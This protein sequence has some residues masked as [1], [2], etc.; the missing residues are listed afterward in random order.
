[1]PPDNIEAA[2]RNGK[3][4]FAGRS[5]D[6]ECLAMYIWRFTKPPGDTADTVPHR[7]LTNDHLA[8]RSHLR[9]SK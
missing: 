2:I 1:M 4:Q 6:Q 5:K 8:G 7:S 3:I 9:S